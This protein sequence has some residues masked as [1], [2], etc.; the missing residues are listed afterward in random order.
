MD[1]SKVP[2]EQQFVYNR[3]EAAIVTGT[4]EETIDCWLHDGLPA[5]RQGRLI[6]IERTSLIE[7]LKNRAAAR[8]GFIRKKAPIKVDAEAV[9]D[10]FPGYSLS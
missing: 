3:K 2:L 1:V 9:D 5:F 7:W 10:I 4:S 8:D 6:C